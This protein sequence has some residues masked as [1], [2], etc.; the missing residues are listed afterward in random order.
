VRDYLRD[1][2]ANFSNIA[3]CQWRSARDLALDPVGDSEEMLKEPR[4]IADPCDWHR[5]AHWL[6]TERSSLDQSETFAEY[7]FSFDWLKGLPRGQSQFLVGDQCGAGLCRC[8]ENEGRIL[9]A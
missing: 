4:R 1:L 9:I 7:A 5:C 2:A 3:N 8:S 6:P